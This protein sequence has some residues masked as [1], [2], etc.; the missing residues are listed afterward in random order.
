LR[1]IE[2]ERRALAQGIDEYWDKVQAHKD[3]GREHYSPPI[4]RLILRTLTTVS[5]AIELRMLKEYC[6]RRSHLPA[7]LP[8]IKDIDTRVLALHTLRCAMASLSG[9]QP[10]SHIARAISSALL[11]ELRLSVW[12]KRNATRKRRRNGQRNNAEANEAPRIAAAPG[13]PTWTDTQC[14]HVGAYLINAMIAATGLFRV[15]IVR[16][17][18][19]RGAKLVASDEARAWLDDAHS[20][21]ALFAPVRLPMLIPPVP[22]TSPRSGGYLTDL[23]NRQQLVKSPNK[24]YLSDLAN[25]EMPAVYS[26]VNA[27]QATAWRINVAVLEVAEACWEQGRSLG[28]AMPVRDPLPVPEAPCAKSELPKFKKAEPAAYDAWAREAGRARDANNRLLSKRKSCIDKLNIA[29]EFANEAAIYFPH[30]CDFRGR[31]YPIPEKLNPQSDDLARGLLEFAEGKPLGNRG[32]FWLKVHIANC[33]GVD[34]VSLDERVAWVDERRAAI[35]LVHANPLGAGDIWKQSEDPWQALAA[36]RELSLAWASSDPESFVSHIS[37][38]MDGSCNGLQNFSALLRDPIGG[39]A[40]NLVPQDKPADI[41]AEVAKV[42]AAR[43]SEAARA[44]HRIAAL[45]NGKVTRNIVKQPVMTLPYGA[46]REGM[47]LQIEA[48][49]NRHHPGMLDRCNAREACTYL[50]KITHELI[51]TVVVA[52]RQTMDWLQ[53]VA[54]IVAAEG[55]PVRWTMP[56]GLPVLQPYWELKGNYVSAIVDGARRQLQLLTDTDKVDKRRQALCLSANLIHSFDAAHLMAT[57]NRAHAQG[58]RAFSVVHDCY[59]THAAD[60]DAMHSH[61]R[62]AF[63]DQYRDNLLETFRDEMCSLLPPEVAAKLPPC[64]LPGSLDLNIVRDALYLF[65]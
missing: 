16:R 58:L 43:V 65:A 25:V 33:S 34:K 9:E 24:A 60:T 64:P 42:V 54:R 41:Y 10:V 29:R 19:N 37:I 17:K 12:E 44:G 11:T 30:S 32:L 35:S 5:E 47:R 40:T 45:W 3:A 49:A 2:L 28:K 63:I 4:A 46:T 53:R 57:V 18:A 15:V 7:A 14:I 55:L 22:W 56:A 1:Q 52:A 48:A 59:G 6:R 27:V 51:G 8:L 62:E 23:G 39:K 61:I 20:R 13:L 26:A 50:A 21:A 38:P 36:M 31:I